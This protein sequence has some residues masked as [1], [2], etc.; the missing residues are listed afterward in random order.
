MLLCLLLFIFYFILFW[1]FSVYNNS[2]LKN[3]FLEFLSLGPSVFNFF[4]S[5]SLFSYHLRLYISFR[6]LLFSSSSSDF[7]CFRFSAP[8]R[9]AAI[10]SIICPHSRVYCC[11]LCHVA[12]SLW[13]PFSTSC[14]S[15]P[16]W[17]YINV[18]DFLKRLIFWNYFKSVDIYKF[19]LSNFIHKY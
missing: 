15:M 2:S 8:Q 10:C 19:F 18:G 5:P 17:A 1:L 4:L 9:Y 16:H 3:H 6:F 11:V 13:L 12:V 7:C 14:M